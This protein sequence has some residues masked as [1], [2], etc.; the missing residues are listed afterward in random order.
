M[1][2]YE[3][4]AQLFALLGGVVTYLEEEVNKVWILLQFGTD[5][6]KELDLFVFCGSSQ[7]LP[8]QMDQFL[9]EECHRK[10]RKKSYITCH[11]VN[12]FEGKEC[13]QNKIHTA[14]LLTCTGLW[15]L[16]CGRRG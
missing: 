9:T 11:L 13:Q 5:Y 12:Q 7:H 1:N 6:T 2:I 15:T 3:R 4:V 8:A 16:M 14:T 10:K